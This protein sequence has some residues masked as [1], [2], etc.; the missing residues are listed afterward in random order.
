[1]NCGEATGLGDAVL[2]AQ[3]AEGGT[4]GRAGVHAGPGER[5]H[6]A[7]RGLIAGH[8][9]ELGEITSRGR[10]HISVKPYGAASAIHLKGVI[11]DSELDAGRLLARTSAERSCAALTTI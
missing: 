3:A 10:S 4:A 6:P 2:R 11:Y 9:S 8:L 5:R 1:M 7:D